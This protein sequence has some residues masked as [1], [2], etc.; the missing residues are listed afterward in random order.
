[1]LRQ[2]RGLVLLALVTL[3]ASA[4]GAC[5]APWRDTSADSE[6]RLATTTS[7]DD[8]GL[9]DVILP[10][11]ERRFD[12]RVSVI[13]VGTGQ[14]LELGE[15]GDVDVV[16][17]HARKQEDAFVAAGFG[18]NRRDVMHND[19]VIVG[20]ANDPASIREVATAADAFDRI[21]TAEA[22]FVSRGDESGT[23][24]REREIWDG[25]GHA[26]GPDSSWYRSLG[27]GM[28]ETLLV[29]NEE[30]AYTL[31]DR[32]TFLSM[33]D[34]LPDL[35]I[36]FGGETIAENPDPNLLN[37]YG[38][39][40][41]NPDRHEGIHATLAR[42]FVEWITSPEVQAMIRDFGRDQYGQ[43]LFYPDAES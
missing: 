12:A 35:T 17:V 11:F 34:R 42:Q 39:I 1:M 33:R 4:I 24:T 6:L 25:A 30:S 16:L 28:G 26:P 32:A 38:V 14:A 2:R 7:T 20:P 15:R 19:F 3:V 36:L 21:A 10:D 31:T 18:I 23:H 41:V 29:A 13:A 22:P 9:L 37:P 27:Q 43:P 5:A 8:S 40:Q